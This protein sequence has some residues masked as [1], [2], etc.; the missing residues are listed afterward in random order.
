MFSNPDGPLY[1]VSKNELMMILYQNG[2]NEVFTNSKTNN[3]SNSSSEKTMDS[4][5]YKFGRN[6]IS[7][8]LFS[9]FREDISASYEH[10]FAKGYLGIKIPLI[11]GFG[12][13]NG[14]LGVRQFNDGQYKNSFTSG[15]DINFYPMGQNKISFFTGPSFQIGV[16]DFYY[17]ERVPYIY[18]NYYGYYNNYRTEQR[19]QKDDLFVAGLVN[20]GVLFQPLPNF[21]MSVNLGLGVRYIETSMSDNS[22]VYATFGYHLGYR[23]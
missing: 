10:F 21:N 7:Y 19:T 20:N 14:D 13:G 2:K 18:S 1:S 22:E 23:F 16:V 5:H 9:F 15:L 11:F 6:L 8:N 17:T 3:S 12:S 4:L